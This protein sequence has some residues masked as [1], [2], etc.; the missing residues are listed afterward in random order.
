MNKAIEYVIG[1]RRAERNTDYNPRGQREMLK[2]LIGDR[3]IDLPM[4]TNVELYEICA[5]HLDMKDFAQ[6]SVTMSFRERAENM[7]NGI[8]RLSELSTIAEYYD[9]NYPEARIGQF[10]DEVVLKAAKDVP[11]RDLVAFAKA[12]RSQNDYVRVCSAYGVS[13]NSLRSRKVRGYLEDLIRSVNG[14][15][16]DGSVFEDRK[17][18]SVELNKTSVN[19]VIQKAMVSSRNKLSF[20][21]RV[22]GI[23][24]DAGV[25]KQQSKKKKADMV[26]VAEWWNSLSD[27]E[28]YTALTDVAKIDDNVAATLIGVPFDQLPANAQKMIEIAD[29]NQVLRELIGSKKKKAQKFNIRD[30][31]IY[32]G[33][34]PEIGEAYI[35]AGQSG[36]ITEYY[37]KV[38]AY[39]VSFGGSIGTWML[40]E[41]SLEP[42]GTTANKKKAELVEDN[43][44]SSKKKKAEDFQVASDELNSI[45]EEAMGGDE[46]AQKF[47]ETVFE[48]PWDEAKEKLETEGSAWEVWYEDGVRKFVQ[49]QGSKK[50][51][52]KNQQ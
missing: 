50:Q 30:V 27:E 43:R 5:K 42:A 40:D 44:T 19:D 13:D 20:M 14:I 17:K 35:P 39:D 46:E 3:K 49:M 4:L 9:R 45:I 2:G 15:T 52:V 48:E 31:V 26:D 6:R 32:K 11:Y 10:V 23:M 37:G 34:D 51:E 38:N 21:A 36:V 33:N 12:V 29:Q 7:P 24:A 16:V 8:I 47:L 22:A 1:T 25:Q 41:E 28:K 18:L